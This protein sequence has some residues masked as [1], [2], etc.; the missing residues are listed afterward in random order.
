M[1]PPLRERD[2]PPAMLRRCVTFAPAAPCLFTAAPE[3]KQT[4]IL[5]TRRS[6][7]RA[8]NRSSVNGYQ[9]QGPVPKST[10]RRFAT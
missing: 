6:N 9:G 10:P 5:S 3:T 4:M 1:V 7:T 8:S 2:F